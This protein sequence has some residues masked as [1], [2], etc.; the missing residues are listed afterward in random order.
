MQAVQAQGAE[1]GGRVGFGG[2]EGRRRQR[3]QVGASCEEGEGCQRHVFPR[4]EKL[5]LSVLLSLSEWNVC[6]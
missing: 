3:R 1:E 5:A 4:Q 6:Y 2:G